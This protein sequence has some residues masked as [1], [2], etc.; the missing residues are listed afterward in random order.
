MMIA[1][2]Q[3]RETLLHEAAMLHGDSAARKSEQESR[4]D[5]TGEHRNSNVWCQHP[6]GLRGSVRN[7]PETVIA[8]G[9]ATRV[10]PSVR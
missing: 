4:S 2:G 3:A 9:R 5:G 6:S 8:G 1:W 10:Q 7:A